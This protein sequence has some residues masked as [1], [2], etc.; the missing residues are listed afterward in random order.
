M[1]AHRELNL[2]SEVDPLAR[3]ICNDC[4][5][6]FTVAGGES[7]FVVRDDECNRDPPDAGC[8]LSGG[9][10]QLEA[11]YIVNFLSDPPDA[12]AYGYVA[13]FFQPREERRARHNWA[14]KIA[15]MN[16]IAD[17]I[18]D[19]HESFSVQSLAL[20]IYNGCPYAKPRGILVSGDWAYTW[21]GSQTGGLVGNEV[22]VQG[23]E[24]GVVMLLPSP[25]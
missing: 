6:M 15:A 12:T 13:L 1:S 22:D 21:V 23:S 14:Y 16:S 2:L 5:M 9:A 24:L 18:R 17:H 25:E 8:A 20:A 11:N 10:V 19:N 7:G 3:M 4:S